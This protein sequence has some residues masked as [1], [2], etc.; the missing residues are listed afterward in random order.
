MPR[1]LRKD[2]IAIVLVLILLSGLIS[3]TLLVRP[4]RPTGAKTV[5]SG[6]I[7]MVWDY[8]AKK[9]DNR[10][11]DK[12]I[13]HQGLNVLSPTWFAISKNGTVSDLA[14]KKYVQWAHQNGLEVWAL[15]ENKSD[16]QMTYAALSNASRRK[17]IVRQLVGFVQTYDL[18]GINVDFEA[19]EAETGRYF[20]LLIAELYQELSPRGI[21]LSVDIPFP[22][23]YVEYVYDLKKIADHSDYLVIMA[24]NQHDAYS[25][26]MGPVATIDWVKEGIQE[27]L[28]YTSAQKIILGLPFYTRI[29]TER[30]ENGTL[31]ITSDTDGM[32]SAYEQFAAN[33]SVWQREEKTGQIYAEYTDGLGRH[34]TW[35]EDNHSL[36][37]KLDRV[38]DDHL[39]GVAAWRRG[40]EW[41]ETWAMIAAYFRD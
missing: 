37:L 33:A 36:S 14:D 13:A 34:M 6:E 2:M 15:V 19:L 24:Y 40:L 1:K 29:W 32:R 3:L 39:A 35:L 25:K 12:R 5:V 17:K 20:E 10:W 18:D 41:P 31:H 22:P 9:E 30:K 38:N 16:D 28:Q 23:S 27:T 7:V 26:T 11:P 8:I 4:S 21:C